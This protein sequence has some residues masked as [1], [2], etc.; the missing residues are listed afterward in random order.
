MSDKEVNVQKENLK[1]TSEVH[2]S[3]RKHTKKCDENKKQVDVLPSKNQV[4]CDLMYNVIIINGYV[5]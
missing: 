1:K 5:M 3:S 4:L 2:A